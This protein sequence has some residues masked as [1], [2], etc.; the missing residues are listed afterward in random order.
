M[1]PVRIVLNTRHG[2]LRAPGDFSWC[3]WYLPDPVFV[4]D[5]DYRLY[6]D[7]TFT[8][9]PSDHR[10]LTYDRGTTRLLLE[11]R[12]N[13]GLGEAMFHDI[14][15][16]DG[17]YTR[18]GFIARLGVVANA[19]I[20]DALQLGDG[21]EFLRFSRLDQSPIHAE[22]TQETVMTA[23]VEL[24]TIGDAANRDFRVVH[25]GEHLAAEALGFYTTSA[26][27]SDKECVR[28]HSVMDTHGT[29]TITICATSLGGNHPDPVRM[30]RRRSVLR[31]LPVMGDEKHK[32]VVWYRPAGRD[33]H[34]ISSRCLT[35]IELALRDDMDLPLNPQHHWSIALEVYPG[36]VSHFRT[37]L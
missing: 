18:D 11:S 5:D 21:A 28:S 13:N 36:R 24:T 12:P 16:E 32:P 35:S 22:Q 31:V 15:I 7:V 33:G 30:E 26:W 17:S 8:A 6:V 3:K 10:R 9:I 27:T 25:D 19:A 23:G 29:R 20:A 37:P 14:F 34:P 4:P 1:D 2:T